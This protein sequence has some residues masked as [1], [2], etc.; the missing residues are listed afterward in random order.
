MQHSGIKKGNGTVINVV[1]LLT[2]IITAKLTD[3][4][5]RTKL[6]PKKELF[7]RL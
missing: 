7:T 1:K 4:F 6:L 3:K 2:V 5:P